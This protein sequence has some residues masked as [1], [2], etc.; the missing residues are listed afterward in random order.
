MKRLN[1]D[2][3]SSGSSSSSFNKE[4]GIIELDGRTIDVLNT[5]KSLNKSEQDLLRF[6]EKLKAANEEIGNS[7]SLKIF[8]FKKKI[9]IKLFFNR[10]SQNTK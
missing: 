6:D 7:L 1:P 10:T 8:K 5:I 9:F 2:Y 4:T 3:G